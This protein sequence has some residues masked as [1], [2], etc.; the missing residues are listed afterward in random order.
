MAALSPARLAYRLRPFTH[1]FLDY[2]VSMQ[3]RIGRRREKR[4]GAL[5]TFMTTRGIHIE[6]A[7]SLSTDSTIM[8]LKRFIARRGSPL[9]IYCDN[10]THFRDM[11]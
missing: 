7:H 4:W 3:M 1:C 5:F 6:L 2:F 11:K 9:V 8:A 10:G